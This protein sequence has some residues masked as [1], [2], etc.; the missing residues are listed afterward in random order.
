MA[1]HSS[2]LA[3]KNPM[4]GGAWWAAVHGVTKPWTYHL[5]L[6]LCIL[7]INYNI[8]GKRFSFTCE[9]SENWSKQHCIPNCA[10]MYHCI[11][12]LFSQIACF[13]FIIVACCKNPTCLSFIVLEEFLIML[14][15]FYL[16]LFH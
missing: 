15:T 5:Y 13:S 3:W 12:F 4:G 1:A 11:V 10:L 16:T 8:L 2:T 14:L 9:N 6:H 7:H